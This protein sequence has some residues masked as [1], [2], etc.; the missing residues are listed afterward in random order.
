MQAKKILLCVSGGIAAYKAID[1]ASQL[2]K[3]GYQVKTVLTQNAMKFVSPLNFA[4]IT[5]NSVHYSLYEDADP[6]PHTTLADWAELVVVAP[7]TANTI[8]KAANGIAD[9]LLSAILLAHSKSVL[10]VPAM[11]ADMYAALPTQANLKLLAQRDHYIMQPASGMLACGYEG[12]G[13]YPSN[14]EVV[15]AINT[16]LFYDK[17]LQGIRVLVTAGATIEYID[18]VRFITNLSSGKMGLALARALALRGAE[19]CLVYGNITLP[20]PHY[21]RESVHCVS[22]QD[23]HDA[24]V[25]RFERMDWVI[26]CAAVT[27][28]KIAEPSGTKLPKEK[29]YSLKLITTG[30]ILQELGQKKQPQQKLI[31]FAAQTNEQVSKG[32]EKFFKK[33]LDMVCINDI[34]VAG[35]DNSE[36]TV[37]A[38]LPDYPNL[39]D[40]PELQYSLLKGDKFTVAQELISLIKS[41]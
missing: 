38:K 34:S 15:A 31:G 2:H 37:V 28:Y 19:V 23:M 6:I 41:L 36:L 21:L 24:V 10:F 13:R 20:L 27:D 29:D 8:A 9:D 16:Y 1:L 4:A 3:L 35:S 7:A 17:D 22:A 11:N 40:N 39:E 33:K 25:N 26:K 18:P 12:V 32:V 14:E 5:Q 30:D